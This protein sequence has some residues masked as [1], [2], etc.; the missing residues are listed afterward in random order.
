MPLLGKKSPGR[1]LK[2]S[3]VVTLHLSTTVDIS[4]NDT[5]AQITTKAEANLIEQMR[6]QLDRKQF[7]VRDTDIEY[8]EFE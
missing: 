4:D 2:V 5:V 3:T 8:Q 7:R 6:T 1:R